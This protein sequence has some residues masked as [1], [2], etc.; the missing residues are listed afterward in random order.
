[1]ACMH[2]TTFRIYHNDQNFVPEEYIEIDELIA[3]T[4][5]VLNQKGYTTKFCC[6]GHPLGNCLWRTNDGYRE[7]S[8]P[9]VDCYI[10]FA[11]G[12]SLPSVPPGFQAEESVNRSMSVVLRKEYRVTN[13]F[14]A[15]FFTKARQ[16]LDTMEQLYQ[17][18][19]ELPDL[20]K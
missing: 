4:I 15:Q 1:M 13:A 3:P 17:W 19:L 11:E 5:Q 7:T 2:K 12:I 20:K 18:A 10:A 6:S 14:E 9:I 8:G 16:I